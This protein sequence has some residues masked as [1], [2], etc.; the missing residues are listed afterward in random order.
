MAIL[1]VVLSKTDYINI[2]ENRIIPRM[3]EIDLCGRVSEHMF[4]TNCHDGIKSFKS[5]SLKL[6]EQEF[7]TNM[8]SRQIT[9]PV[10]DSGIAM[11][12]VMLQFL[13]VSV[14]FDGHYKEYKHKNGNIILQSFGRE[15][16]VLANNADNYVFK[17]LSESEIEAIRITGVNGN[18]GVAHLTI[19]ETKSIPLNTLA[20]ACSAM[21][22]LL[23]FR[24]I[25]PIQS[26]N[27]VL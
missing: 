12:R 7:Y 2:I 20:L 17:T 18:K 26:K 14:H 13:G 1:T 27:A 21:I 3:R 6:N 10:L 16:L 11:V 22:K 15:K 5:V 19:H 24:L 25:K 9:D 23:N 8:H 4:N